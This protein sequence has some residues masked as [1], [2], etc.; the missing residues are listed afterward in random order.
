MEHTDTLAKAI[1]SQTP[2]SSEALHDKDLERMAVR[3]LDYSI[4]PV[5]TMYYLLSFL[6]RT[7]LYYAAGDTTN[8]FL[9]LEGPGKYW[10]VI[11]KSG[12]T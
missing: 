12:Q 11:S 7:L 4:L 9:I 1:E 2:G 10:F 5:M 8:R 6:V 3:K